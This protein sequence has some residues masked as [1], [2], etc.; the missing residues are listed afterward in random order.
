MGQILRYA[1]FLPQWSWLDE[2]DFSHYSDA[3]LQQLVKK[4]V[5]EETGKEHAPQ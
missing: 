2:V 4:A 1:I 3:E 5:E